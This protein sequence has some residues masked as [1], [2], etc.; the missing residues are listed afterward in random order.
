M[1][2]LDENPI[3]KVAVDPAIPP[4]EFIDENG[5]ISGIAGAHLDIIAAKLNIKF[6]WIGNKSFKQGMDKIISKEADILSAAS[7]SPARREF[8]E[9]TDSYID[10]SS[11]IF[12][13]EGEKGFGDMESLKGFKIA[14]VK[15]FALNDDIRRDFPNLE[16][17]EVDSVAS[18]LKLV[19]SGVVDAHIGSV[20]I[21]SYNIA[22]QGLTNLSVVGVTPYE[23]HVSIGIRSELPLLASVLTKALNSISPMQSS[24]IKREWLVLKTKKQT[25]YKTLLAVISIS[26]FVVALI[27]TWNLGLQREVQRRKI[28]EADLILSQAEAV[29]SQII[30]EEAQK[31]A[32]V[33]QASAEVAQMEA[34]MAN[35]AKSQ[36]LANMSHEIRTPLNAIIGFSEVMLSGIFGKIEEPRYI[37]YLNDIKDSGEHLGTVIKDILDLSKIEAGKWQ[38]DEIEF[39]LDDCIND[40]VK[41]IEPHAAQK[42]ISLSK[43]KGEKGLSLNLFGD[44]HAFKRALINILSNAVKFTGEDGEVV[45]NVALDNDGGAIIAVKD[46]GIGIPTSRIKQVLNPFEQAEGAYLNEEGTGLGLPIVKQ[47]IE[48]H[49]GKFS[50]KSEVGMGTTAYMKLPVERVLVIKT[51]PLNSDKIA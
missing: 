25:D 15:D 42:S 31:V 28:A 23:G 48:L 6:E 36:F 11:M 43:G 10:V 22:S 32:E 39:S 41:M 5:R 20:P 13:R 18:A 38:L 27:L 17:I 37:S 24:A 7:P 35:E 44:N 16:I 12:S 50:L 2:W 29:K 4:V 1:E 3:V 49:G 46:N 8:L 19:S 14:Q 30:A 34:E 26:S 21:T 33:A 45:C 47:L 51:I 40:A 9:F